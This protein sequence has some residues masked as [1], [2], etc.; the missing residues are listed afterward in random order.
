MDDERTDGAGAVRPK[1]GRPRDVTIDERVLEATRASLAEVGWGR[2]SMRGVAERSGVSRPA[3]DRRWPS[4]AH[5]VLESILGATPNLDAFDGVDAAG[6]VDAVIDGSFE[7]FDREDVQAAAPGLLATLRDQDDIRQA[8]WAGFSGPAS[9]LVLQLH[10]DEHRDGP[11]AGAVG[12]DEQRR[13]VDAQAAIVIAAGSA[14]FLSLVVG[15]DDGVRARVI[16]S[17][18][19]TLAELVDTSGDPTNPDRP[20]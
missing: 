3:I 19:N 15:G 12:A 4:K 18:A 6:W 17:L 10:G 9:D 13:L 1:R 14:F 16:E 2:T 7:L 8:L 20:R 11:G 5:L